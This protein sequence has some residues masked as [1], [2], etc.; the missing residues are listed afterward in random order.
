MP[1]SFRTA[2]FHVEV[3]SHES[4]RRIVLHEFPKRDMPYA[5]DMGRRAYDI[6]VRAYC[7]AYPF[8]TNRPLYQRD[9]RVPRNLLIRELE[10]E[11]AGI[12]QLPS[13]RPVSVVVQRY[14]VTEEQ[15][16]GGFCMFDISFIES[17]QAA[18]A[19]IDTRGQVIGAAKM[20]TKVFTT[21]MNNEQVVVTEVLDTPEPTPQRRLTIR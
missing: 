4:G 7:V 9:Y 19:P 10:T 17:G 6:T 2:Q 21:I 12:L 20:V 3:G 16:A 13:L 5:E 18:L 15:K 14:R 8:D 11:G 1:A